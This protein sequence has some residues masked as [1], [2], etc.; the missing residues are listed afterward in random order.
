[1]LITMN[2]EF[3][4]YINAYN[5]YQYIR[6]LYLLKMTYSHNCEFDLYTANCMST[7]NNIYKRCLYSVLD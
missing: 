1:M 6:L 4:I 5:F 2:Y 7:L 3:H